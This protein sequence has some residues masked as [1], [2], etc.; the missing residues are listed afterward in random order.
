M[1]GVEGVEGVG[2]VGGVGKGARDFSPRRGRGI[3][4]A[5]IL[6]FQAFPEPSPLPLSLFARTIKKGEGSGNYPVANT[7]GP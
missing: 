1:G 4:S 3:Y 7:A 2:G 6:T 5:G